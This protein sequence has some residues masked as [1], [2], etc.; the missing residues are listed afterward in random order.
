M[1]LLTMTATL[2]SLIGTNGSAQTGAAPAQAKGHRVLEPAYSEKYEYYEVC[3]CSEKDLQCDLTLKAIRCSDGKKYDSV[4]NWKV[5]WDY[6]YNREGG[7]CSTEAYRVTVDV[8][9]RLPKW[10]R[11]ANAPQQ[12]VDKWESYTK[13]LLLH[14]MAHRDKAL[15]AAADLTR[16]IAQL[17]PSRTCWSLDEEVNRVSRARLN[18]LIA[19]QEEYDALTGHGNTEGVRFP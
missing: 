8:V 19:D 9:F 17:P 18:K 1:L 6:G 2:A 7:T 15:E 10:V 14:E 16:S 11:D 13:N 5:T 12:L 4:T 3:G